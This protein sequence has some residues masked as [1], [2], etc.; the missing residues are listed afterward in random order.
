MAPGTS[1]VPIGQRQKPRW[2]SDGFFDEDGEPVAV[3]ELA[4]AEAS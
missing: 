1:K 4:E 3:T 2:L